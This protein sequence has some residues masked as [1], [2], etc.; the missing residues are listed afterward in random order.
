MITWQ[1]SKKETTELIMPDFILREYDGFSEMPVKLMKQ[2]A[3]YQDGV[4]VV[5]VALEERQMSLNI[6]AA[7]RTKKDKQ[8]KRRELVQAFSPHLGEGELIWEQ[9]EDTYKIACYP[10]DTPTMP[11]NTGGVA[12]Q[13]VIVN[14]EAPDPTWYSEPQNE[15]ILDTSETERINLYNSGDVETPLYIEFQG[16]VERPRII[17]R[18]T[19]KRII[20]KDALGEN[21]ELQIY[22]RYNEKRVTLI[23]EDGQ[24]YNAFINLEVGSELFYLRPG[25][26]Q[27]DFRSY[28]GEPEII[29]RH[30]SRYAG[31]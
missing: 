12:H 16:P 6:L 22:T 3:P 18:S 25:N 23:E 9:E 11:S 20:Y 15:E 2:K 13:E 30:Y 10:D 1:N 17:N 24:R 8:Q 31:V 27:V 19:G 26:N 4:T 28:T 14:L 7:G 5:D 21:E 29:F